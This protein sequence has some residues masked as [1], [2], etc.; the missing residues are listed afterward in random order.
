VSTKTLEKYCQRIKDDA[1]EEERDREALQTAEDEHPPAEVE[2][3]PEAL[4][5]VVKEA[6]ADPRVRRAAVR[7]QAA[8]AMHATA[9]LVV[10]ADEYV[11]AA[12][13]DEP[14]THLEQIKQAVDGWQHILRRFTEA[15]A[16]G[17]RGVVDED[18]ELPL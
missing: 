5:R 15:S 18:V 1:E 7:H 16:P 13:R 6:S 9:E 10:I 3:V 2:E 17:I 4:E 14:E 11:A 12:M 8:K